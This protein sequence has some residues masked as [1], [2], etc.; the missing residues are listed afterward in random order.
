MAGLLCRNFYGNIASR[1][2]PPVMEGSASKGILCRGYHR[3]EFYIPDF[4]RSHVDIQ[5]IIGISGKKI[6]FIFQNFRQEPLG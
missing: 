5:D 1:P 2:S 3:K 6:I 4:G